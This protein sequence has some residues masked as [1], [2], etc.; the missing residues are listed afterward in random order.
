MLRSFLKMYRADLGVRFENVTT[1]L[2]HLPD[3]KYKTREEQNSFHDSLLRRLGTLPGV[4]ST[5]VATGLPAS[6]TATRQFQL[7]TET[8]VPLE[9]APSVSIVGVGPDYFKILGAGV[10]GREFT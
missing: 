6:R 2:I 9:S 8:S 5:S 3:K 4:E 1:M 7:G 10:V